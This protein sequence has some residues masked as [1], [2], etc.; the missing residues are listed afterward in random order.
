MKIFFSGNNSEVLK[1]C[2]KGYLLMYIKANKKQQEIK[3]LVV[4]SYKFL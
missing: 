2:G 4:A 1:I 3:D